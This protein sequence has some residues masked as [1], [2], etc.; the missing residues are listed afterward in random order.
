MPAAKKPRQAARGK[1]PAAAVDDAAM[2]AQVASPKIDN[3]AYMQE[4][5]TDVA[6]G[7]G[8]LPGH[9]GLGC[10]GPEFESFLMES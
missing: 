5:H 3:L 6:K 8:A 2:A 9:Q 4:V 10:C 1:A 7:D